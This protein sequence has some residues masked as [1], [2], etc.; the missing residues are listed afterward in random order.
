MLFR[1]LVHVTDMDQ[2][3]EHIAYTRYAQNLSGKQIQRT[4]ENVLRSLGLQRLCGK[5]DGNLAY[6]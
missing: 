3:L 1:I 6:N 5:L 2:G 4:Q